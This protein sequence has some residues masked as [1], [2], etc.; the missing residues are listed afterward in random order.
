MLASFLWGFA[1]AATLIVGGAFALRWRVS[2]FALG[3]IEAFGSGVLIS[4]VAF[5]LVQE[6]FDKVHSDGARASVALGLFAGSAT[7]YVGDLLIDRMGGADRKR[8]GGGQA[9]G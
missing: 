5:E 2:D 3:L 6:A 4:A 9:A 8:S 1:G 7:F